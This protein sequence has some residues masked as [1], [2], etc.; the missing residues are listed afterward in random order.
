MAV[1]T[2]QQSGDFNAPATWGTSGLSGSGSPV[3]G[4]HIPDATSDVVVDNGHN[5]TL[6]GHVTI[7]SLANSAGGT[8]TG[9]GY[10]L[11]IDGES[12]GGYALDLRS[13]V[14]GNLD[15]TINSGATS[16]FRIAPSSGTLRELKI[17]DANTYEYVGSVTGLVGF[18]LAAGTVQPYNAVNDWTSTGDSSI[19]GTFGSADLTRDNEVSMGSIKLN[20]GGV[21][22]ATSVTN[23]TSNNSSNSNRAIDLPTGTFNH[24]GGM[25]SYLGTGGSRFLFGDDDLYD[26]KISCNGSSGSAMTLDGDGSNSVTVNGSLILENQSGQGL[27]VP[28]GSAGYELTVRG[29]LIINYDTRTANENIILGY[30]QTCTAAWTIVGTLMLMNANEK[31]RVRSTSGTMI[32]GGLINQGGRID[33]Q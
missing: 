32:M 9:A 27:L 6:V 1:F 33:S 12:S 13:T 26:F 3:G 23:V 22:H 15:I 14:S 31:V 30:N 2:T 24:N 7:N 8:I 18:I 17:N 20:S 19:T 21:F 11:T 4:T 5:L 10:R 28:L 29:N 25:L 16:L